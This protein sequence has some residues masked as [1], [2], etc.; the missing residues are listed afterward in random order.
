MFKGVKYTNNVTLND[1]RIDNIKEL[2]NNLNIN[3]DYNNW[4]LNEDFDSEGKNFDIIYSY[5]T[6]YHLNNPVQCIKK[7]SNM[8]KEFIIISTVGNYCDEDGFLYEK[9][10]TNPS[11]SYNGLG[12]RPSRKW[13]ANELSKYFEYIYFPIN[14]PE[15]HDFKK[16][17]VN[18]KD[19]GKYWRFVIIGSKY[20]M[21]NKMLTETMPMVYM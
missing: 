17:Y 21:E 8:C 19:D 6:L 7:L 10:N 16:Y 2:S 20:K 11:Q 13:L 15:H 14:Q 1:V 18:K 12:C 5:G 9:E 4:D 3:L